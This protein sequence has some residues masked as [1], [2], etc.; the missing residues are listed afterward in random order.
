MILGQHS[1]WV[2]LLFLLWERIFGDN[3]HRYFYQLDALP[4]TRPTLS[5]FRK[6]LKAPTSTSEITHSPHTFV[7]RQRTF[8]GWDIS[9]FMPD[10][11]CEYRS[12]KDTITSTQPTFLPFDV[13]VSMRD[14]HRK[15]L[16]QLS[17]TYDRFL[18]TSHHCCGK[19][20]KKNWTNFFWW[21]S[22]IETETAKGKNVG[23]VEVTVSFV[24]T[25]QPT[26]EYVSW[27]LWFYSCL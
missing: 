21:R 6:K 9:L 13:S 7:I 8:E 24:I 27:V 26:E 4:V 5:E 12:Y 1:A 19:N 11:Q 20:W 15:K 10:F 16:V 2:I 22:L 23:C 18:A 17:H 14:L 3:W 25:N